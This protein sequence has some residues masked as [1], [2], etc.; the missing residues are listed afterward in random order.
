MDLT[1]FT[2][3]CVRLDDGDRRL[4][5]DPGAFSEVEQALDGVDAVLITHEHADHIDVE[6]LKA[7]AKKNSS[8]RV[9]APNSVTVQLGDLGAPA[10][11]MVEGRRGHRLRGVRACAE[12]LRYPRRSA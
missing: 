7:A 10:R 5:I 2:H 12:G 11:A 8:L 6:K 3:A 1:K 4:V 9:R